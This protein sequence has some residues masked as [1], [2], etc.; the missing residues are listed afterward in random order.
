VPLVEVVSTM[1]DMDTHTHHDLSVLAT[2]VRDMEQSLAIKREQAINRLY[3]VDRDDQ[4][5]IVQLA[6][7]HTLIRSAAFLLELAA[8]TAKRP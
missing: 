3:R 8:A 7:I 1:S 4:N 2:G 6:E 5:N